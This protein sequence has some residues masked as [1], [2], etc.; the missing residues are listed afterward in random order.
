[1]YKDLKGLKFP[2]N[3][4]IKFFFKNSLH[5]MQG[6]VLEYA[7]SNGNNLS[8]FASYGWQC[9]GVDLSTQNVKDGE[10]NFKEVL[11]ASD[12]RFFN[13]DILHFAKAHKDILAD[14]FLVPN[15]INY[16]KRDDFLALLQ[17]AREFKAY[18]QNAHFFLRTR[19][20]KDYRYGLGTKIAHNSFL[21]DCDES[22]GEMGCINTFYQ[23]YELVE[24]LR[25]YL[26]LYDFKV[27]HYESTNVMGDEERLVNDADI[28][29][30][31]RI[32]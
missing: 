14:V 11:K 15:V 31:G 10:F 24:Y 12:F 29:I 25:E 20:V 21:L 9:L 6:K 1:M 7:C 28:I 27:L 26:H 32:K 30:Y 22:T 13:E 3:A 19:G 5:K 2:D 8:L 4:V 18:K 23:E 16:L 17:G